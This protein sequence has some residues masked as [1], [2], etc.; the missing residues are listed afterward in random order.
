MGYFSIVLGS[1]ILLGFSGGGYFAA[2]NIVNL[3]NSNNG[4]SMLLNITENTIPI[5]FWSVFFAITFI[6]FLI[7]FNMLMLGIN[8]I[9]LSQIKKNLERR[10]RR[11]RNYEDEDE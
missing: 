11:P 10:R 9:K 8:N 1:L 4:M 5:I 6:G 7:F 3:L 2:T